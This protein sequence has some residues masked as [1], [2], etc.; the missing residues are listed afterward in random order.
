MFLQVLSTIEENKL[1]YNDISK[2]SLNKVSLLKC[3]PLSEQIK[4]IT[5]CPSVCIFGTCTIIFYF[6]YII[7]HNIK[8]CK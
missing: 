6:P 5:I 4:Y 1:K 7:L 3:Y 8:N 2:D